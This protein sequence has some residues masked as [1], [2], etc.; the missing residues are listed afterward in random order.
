MIPHRT[1]DSE[2]C[3]NGLKGR[4]AACRKRLRV[5]RVA[6]RTQ[7]NNDAEGLFGESASSVSR[8]DNCDA[9]NL[10][11]CPTPP[12]SVVLLNYRL[13]G[14]EPADNETLQLVGEQEVGIT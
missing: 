9:G 6:N 14:A 5:I 3:G 13:G 4:V 12:V 11:E 2:T 10:A 7:V 8:I 1:P